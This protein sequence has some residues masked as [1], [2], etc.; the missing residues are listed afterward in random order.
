MRIHRHTHGAG[1]TLQ[2]LHNMLVQLRKNCNH[3][4][5]LTAS[6]DQSP[7]FPPADRI[8]E[9]GGKF[10]LLERLLVRL[11]AGGHKVLIFSQVRRPAFLTE[12]RRCAC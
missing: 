12:S 8:V 7:M 6:S 11:K 1:Q 9:Q 2:S 4:D 10:Q 3:P 5:I